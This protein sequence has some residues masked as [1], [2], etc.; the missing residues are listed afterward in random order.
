MPKSWSKRFNNILQSKKAAWKDSRKASQKDA[1][2]QEVVAAI[3]DQVAK[4]GTEDPIPAGLE[5]VS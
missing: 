1:I 4:S 5:K 3:R 2:V